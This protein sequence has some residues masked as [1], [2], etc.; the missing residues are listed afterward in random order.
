MQK[1]IAK[2]IRKHTNNWSEMASKMLSRGSQNRGPELLRASPGTSR[3]PGPPRELLWTPRDLPGTLQDLIL[4][5]PELPG[6]HFRTILADSGPWNSLASAP[7]P[8]G[9]MINS[10]STRT[11]AAATTTAT[12]TK[13]TAAITTTATTK[14]STS[15]SYIPNIGAKWYPKWCP[16]GDQNRA[17]GFPRA[18]PGHHL[19]RQNNYKRWSGE[20]GYGTDIP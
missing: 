6:H 10:S 11:T 2:S 4:A 20:R 14:I 16:G 8:L 9:V 18:L 17:P 15:I 3:A 12:T 19:K 1:F 13:T 7:F 5:A